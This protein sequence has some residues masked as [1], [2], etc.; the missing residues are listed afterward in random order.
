MS[1][2]IQTCRLCKKTNLDSREP[3]FRYGARHSAHASC[4]LA[5]W[6]A[7]FFD[8]IPRADIEK[9]PYFTLRDSGLLDVARERLKGGA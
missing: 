2:P 8:M 1:F 7:H 4:A 5:K 6:G 9:I 3:L